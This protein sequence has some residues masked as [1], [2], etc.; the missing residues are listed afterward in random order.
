MFVLMI[1]NWVLHSLSACS[2]RPTKANLYEFGFRWNLYSLD[3][4]EIWSNQNILL[5]ICCLG[6][7]EMSLWWCDGIDV[8]RYFNKHFN[9]ISKFDRNSFSGMETASHKSNSWT[10]YLN[11][12]QIKAHSFAKIRCMSYISNTFSMTK[13]HYSTWPI[14][15]CNYIKAKKETRRLIFLPT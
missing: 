8:R 6:M 3:F 4:N 1:G 5:H 14:G 10:V 7:W 13:R 12:K 2:T 11:R 15:S 9:L